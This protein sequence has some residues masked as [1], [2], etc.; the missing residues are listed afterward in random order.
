MQWQSGSGRNET[1]CEV[2]RTHAH[3]VIKSWEQENAR[4]YSNGKMAGATRAMLTFLVILSVAASGFA[5]KYVYSQSVSQNFNVI[6]SRAENS[7]PK[8]VY[9]TILDIR[10]IEQIRY[11]RIKGQH[12][13]TWTTYTCSYDKVV[14]A[15]RMNACTS[16]R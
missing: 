14:H 15:Q 4:E 11:K 2:A 13:N 7:R 16:Y 9:K 12:T 3:F 5:G 8:G 10:Y 6:C 1:T